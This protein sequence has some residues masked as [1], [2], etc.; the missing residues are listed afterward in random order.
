M[1]DVGLE[2]RKPRLLRERI[3]YSLVCELYNIAKKSYIIGHHTQQHFIRILTD[4]LWL[5]L[6]SSHLHYTA[7]YLHESQIG[8]GQVILGLQAF[9]HVLS[10]RFHIKFV[11]GS[12]VE[13]NYP[14]SQWCRSR[15]VFWSEGFRAG[16]KMQI[17]HHHA[18]PD[19]VRVSWK[20]AISIQNHSTRRWV[21]SGSSSSLLCKWRVITR[22]SLHCLL[23][24]WPRVHVAVRRIM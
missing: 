13:L 6:A 17:L 22:L 8:R 18:H 1:H 14:R 16:A 19:R 2:N 24:S 12:H 9:F 7:H 15:I 11:H 3:K 4:L 20:W 21:A 5:L 10:N 23:E